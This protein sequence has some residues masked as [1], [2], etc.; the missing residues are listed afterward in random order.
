[1]RPAIEGVG[2]LLHPL[3]HHG[4]ADPHFPQR[5][6]EVLEEGVGQVLGDVVGRRREVAQRPQHQ[7]HVQGHGFEAPLQRIG[8]AK[9][10]VERRGCATPSAMRW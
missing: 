10:R 8:N 9:C 5:G 4:V 3:R 1:M 6:V 2:E 7:N